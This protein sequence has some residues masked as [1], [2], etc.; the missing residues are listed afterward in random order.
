MVGIRW[1]HILSF[2][3][4]WNIFRGA[5]GNF[6]L[7]F[8]VATEPPEKNIIVRKMCCINASA[9]S[10]TQALVRILFCISCLS[11]LSTGKKQF[12]PQLPNCAPHPTERASYSCG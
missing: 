6:P 11:I 7:V 1:F 5:G 3:L 9:G 12:V 4:T 10:Q 2:P 8:W